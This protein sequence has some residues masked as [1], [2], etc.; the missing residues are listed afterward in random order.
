MAGLRH[1]GATTAQPSS[2]SSRIGRITPRPCRWRS[3]T[4][5]RRSSASRR[6][7]KICRPQHARVRDS[8]AGVRDPTDD[9]Q[10]CTD[11]AT[12]VAATARPDY[13]G[14]HGSIDQACRGSRRSAQGRQ[15]NTR[16]ARGRCPPGKRR[17]RYQPRSAA[18]CG[19]R[20]ERSVLQ[21]VTRHSRGARDDAAAVD[22]GP[23]RCRGLQAH[24]RPV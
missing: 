22:P 9:Q 10:T 3:P 24:R 1:E 2:T 20:I 11:R 8:A 18:K 17:Y 19:D 15:T 7:R 4:R 14:Q 23:I 6:L 13:Q 21:R 12:A 16:G 5:T